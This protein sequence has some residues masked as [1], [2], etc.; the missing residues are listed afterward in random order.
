MPFKTDKPWKNSC[1]FWHHI[2][3]QRTATSGS[4]TSKLEIMIAISPYPHSAGR[5][6]LKTEVSVHTLLE[7]FSQ[8][9]PAILDLWFRKTHAR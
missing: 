9:F 2:M 1:N 8:Q 7:K 4:L 3:Q 6:N 5:L